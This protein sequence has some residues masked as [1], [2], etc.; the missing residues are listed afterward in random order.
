MRAGI[1]VTISRLAAAV[2]VV[3]MTAAAPAASAEQL[4]PYRDGPTHT[5]GEM[6]D[7]PLA[8]P[9]GGPYYMFDT[10]YAPR[11]CGQGVVHHAQDLMADK[12]TPVFAAA[13]GTVSYVNWSWNPDA[14]DPARCCT[15]AIRHDDGWE[16]WYIHLNNDTPGTDDGMGW[17]IAP[18]ILPGV[19]VAAGELIGWVGDSGNAENTDPHLHFELHDPDDVY[20]N[21]YQALLDAAASPAPLTGTGIETLTCQGRVA[22]IVGDTDGDGMITGTAG[23]DVIVGS[24][25]DDVIVAGDGNDVICALDGAD[26]IDGGTG[27][28]RIDAGAGNDSLVGGRGRDLLIAGSGDD[29]VWGGPGQDVIRTGLGANTIDGGNGHD[30]VDY[31]E[32]S[33][34]VSID[35][36]TGSSTGDSFA[37]VENAR[38]SR[39]GDVLVGDPVRN[40]LRGED[41]DDQIFGDAG[42]DKLIGGRGVDAADG[43]IGSD[44]CAVES[45]IACER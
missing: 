28:D 20:V 22:T 23:N 33:S 39:F 5:F 11:C 42:N 10:F 35:L 37:S 32:A 12:M 17:G 36:R 26:S 4:P 34:S 3:A 14:I 27:N 44:V 31:R 1:M 29:T 40:K 13:S 19:N 41:G 21:P 18:G 45:S 43:G 9:L 6:V 16:S 38:G 8:F 2:A 24:N 15:L 25:N 7:Y 30:E